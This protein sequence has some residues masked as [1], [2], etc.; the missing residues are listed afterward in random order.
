[1]KKKKYIVLILVF[2]TV[3]ILIAVSYYTAI[4]SNCQ[5]KVNGKNIEYYSKCFS[6]FESPKKYFNDY[7][8]AELEIKNVVA[9]GNDETIELNFDKKPVR[10]SLLEIGNSDIEFNEV[11]YSTD[12]ELFQLNPLYDNPECWVS[13][14]AD[15]GIE[16]KVIT[17]CVYNKDY[18]NNYD[19]ENEKFLADSDVIEA[20]ISN[21]VLIKVDSSNYPIESSAYS[22]DIINNDTGSIETSAFIVEKYVNGKWY[23]VEKEMNSFVAQNLPTTISLSGEKLAG[24]E[25]RTVNLETSLYLIF[26][27]GVGFY[28]N[29][30]V[31]RY[32]IPYSFNNDIYY[33][34]SNL[35]TVG[36]VDEN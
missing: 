27:D 31:Y 1:M 25:K 30:G 34:V 4:K 6:M 5:I 2:I 17:F 22:F 33:A 3:C 21:T 24:G 7:A 26:D 28:N 13:V 15:Y 12:E 20:N 11:E 10:V 18:E 23:I 29:S 36:Y 19:D 16:K 14:V 8:N 32:V 9:I 35:F